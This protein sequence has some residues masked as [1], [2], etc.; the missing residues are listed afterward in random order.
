MWTI[1]SHY[2]SGNDSY[3]AEVMGSA[4]NAAVIVLHFQTFGLPSLASLALTALGQ[5]RAGTTLSGNMRELTTPRV[6]K[7]A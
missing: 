7:G 6:A 1:D 4:R 3:L 2:T 5:A